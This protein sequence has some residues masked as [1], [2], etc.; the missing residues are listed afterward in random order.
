MLKF[1]EA[2]AGNDVIYKGMIHCDCVYLVLI[3]WHNIYVYNIHI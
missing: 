2:V 1:E 3:N